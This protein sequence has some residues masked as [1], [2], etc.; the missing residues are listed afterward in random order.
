MFFKQSPPDITKQPT[1][2]TCATY[3]GLKV[4]GFDYPPE[5]ITSEQIETEKIA[6]QRKARQRFAMSKFSNEIE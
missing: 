1:K 6:Q 4:N 3:M 5:E 2:R